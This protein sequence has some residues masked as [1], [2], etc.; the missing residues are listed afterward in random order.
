MPW[1]T[2]QDY[3]EAIQN[4]R[5]NLADTELQSGTPELTPLGLPRPITGGF[6][7]VYK[8]QCGKRDWAVRCFLREVQDQQ[9]RYAAISHHLA[10]VKLPYT[11]GFDFVEQGIRIRGQWYPVLKM[12][13]VH[14][15]PLNV[16]IERK[17]Q[18]SA[19]LRR[20]AE[21]WRTMAQELGKAGIAHGDLQHGN[22]IVANDDF[23]IIDY[24]GMYVPGLQGEKSN[25]LGHRNYQS[26]KRD[27]DDFGPYL[28]HFSSWVIYLSL[29]AL[30][31]EPDLW[32]QTG[33]GDEHLLFR[34][35]DFAQPTSSAT[36]SLLAQIGDKQLQSLTTLF[37]GLIAREPRDIP[38]LDSR[39]QGG[40]GPSPAL[41]WMKGLLGGSRPA[42]LAIAAPAG[43]PVQSL[44]WD[45]NGISEPAVARRFRLPM[46][47]VRVLAGVS[48]L[49]SVLLAWR[50]HGAFALNLARNLIVAAGIDAAA[51]FTRY[52]QEPDVREMR[53][54]VEKRKRALH[55]LRSIEGAKADHEKLKSNALA[56]AD[57]RKSA[58]YGLKMDREKQE[59]KELTA[60]VHALRQERDSLE[61]R[62]KTLD[63][64]Q[65]EALEKARKR[66]LPQI[67]AL[68]A[69]IDELTQARLK[70]V[71]EMVISRQKEYLD[72]EL[73][74]FRLGKASLPG[75]GG[76]TRM[77]LKLHGVSTAADITAETLKLVSA[78]RANTLHSWRQTLE[79]K[80]RSAMPDFVRDA[81]T[82]RSVA[83]YDR[84]TQT[85]E[86]RRNEKQQQLEKEEE[87]V[88]AR[89]KGK[90]DALDQEQHDAQ[91]KAKQA[92]QAI[93]NRYVGEYQHIE[94]ALAK[95]TTETENALRLIASEQ[96]Q[97]QEQLPFYS[98]QMTKL[99]GEIAAYMAL[100]FKDYL[101]SV[102]L[103][104]R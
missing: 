72:Q 20:L 61:V 95:L 65:G 39:L 27:P 47:G 24:D 69:R 86:T 8:L 30:S 49:V 58:L 77:R 66:Y 102:F 56:A 18:D 83:R 84:R 21:R 103:A 60:V 50:F 43:V 25:E 15:E 6:A 100:G 38:G 4:P 67:A 29:I 94:E 64:Q 7:S 16:Y 41:D 22:V 91:A 101:R 14:G 85:M 68:E 31:E 74:R 12:E 76:M 54:L 46:L 88:R 97:S 82:A 2:P 59:K 70:T 73:S 52:R 13:W 10:S 89:F 3:N 42:A 90:A 79:A 99:E 78:K 104:R 53:R 55:A 35:Q 51:L 34:Q 23:K 62:R 19:A 11:V 9:K 71:G 57:D 93:S 75:I 81:E 40:S 96:G 26:P 33:A 63:V 87:A 32:H 17:L 48:L 36:F 44:T 45:L 37:Q 5:L 28:D 92:S 98:R 1:P 80:A